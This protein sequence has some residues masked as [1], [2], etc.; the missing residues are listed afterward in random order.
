MSASVA[1]AISAL[2]RECANAEYSD[3]YERGLNLIRHGDASARLLS[4][5]L[6]ALCWMISSIAGTQRVRRSLGRLRRGVLS[7]EEVADREMTRAERDQLAVTARRLR[8]CHEQNVRCREGSYLVHERLA[9]YRDKFSW[10]TRYAMRLSLDLEERFLSDEEEL[11]ETL[12]LIAS[13][14]F[15]ESMRQ[16]LAHHDGQTSD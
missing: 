3:L 10:V 15:M 4:L 5:E 8:R 16:T 9:L 12:A 2:E 6:A 11:V 13:T 14:E 1:K 7:L